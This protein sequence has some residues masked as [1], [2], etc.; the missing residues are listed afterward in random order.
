MFEK[1]TRLHLRFPS[2][3][4]LLTVED[5]W[6]LPLTS[7]TGKANLDDIARSLN[8]ALKSD[9]NVSFVKPDTSEDALTKLQFDIV[10]HIISTKMTE[11]AEALAS[12]AK[13]E[14]KQQLLEVLER[15]QN[16]QLENLSVDELTKLIESL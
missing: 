6:D 12:R 4:G 2:P 5:L 9:N 1:A 14:K 11:N 8:A 16:A 7:T 15:K 13:R 3:K 10:L